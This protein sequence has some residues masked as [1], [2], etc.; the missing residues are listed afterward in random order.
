MTSVVCKLS[1][2]ALWIYVFFTHQLH[3]GYQW[4]TV[5][6]FVYLMLSYRIWAP[7]TQSSCKSNTYWYDSIL[8]CW[9]YRDVLGRVHTYSLN[10]SHIYYYY[11]TL[12]KFIRYS[13]QQQKC[14]IFTIVLDKYILPLM[15]D[16][17]KRPLPIGDINSVIRHCKR[18][19]EYTK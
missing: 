16:I 2:L 6:W 5:F 4:L 9:S 1:T 10:V 13:I 7:Q 8:S 19:L 18:W 11:T 17:W 12:A 15:S 14:L 3:N